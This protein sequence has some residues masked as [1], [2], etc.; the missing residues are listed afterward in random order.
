ML[1]VLGRKQ[2]IANH[3]DIVVTN[4]D[5]NNLDGEEEGEI[6]LVNAISNCLLVVS[7][8]DSP[9]SFVSEICSNNLSKVRW[10]K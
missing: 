1:E 3:G 10:M 5:E 8:G 2:T 4:D 9:S 6:G 7:K